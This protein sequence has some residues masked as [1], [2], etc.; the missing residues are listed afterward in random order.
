MMCSNGASA[1]TAS[2]V[3]YGS[4]RAAGRPAPRSSR[5]ANVSRKTVAPVAAAMRAAARTP[6]SRIVWPPS[7]IAAGAEER[8]ARS[9][10]SIAPSGTDVR[11]CGATG[12]ATPGA[13]DQ[14]AS[15][16]STSVAIWPP[17][18]CAADAASAASAAAERASRVVASQCETGRA[19][20]STSLESGAPS[21]PCITAW[22]PTRFTIGVRAL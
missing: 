11:G 9:A 14:P 16:G 22:S 7:R 8:S 19:M 5:V 6:G 1:S 12:A 4:R 10:C 21:G 13:S 15:A 17:K 18:L 2:S 20:P 3:R